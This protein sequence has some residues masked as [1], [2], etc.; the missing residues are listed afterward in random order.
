MFDVF[1]FYFWN[2]SEVIFGKVF[3]VIKEQSF[4]NL[5]TEAAVWI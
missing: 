2:D 1:E 4:H 5:N 3:G